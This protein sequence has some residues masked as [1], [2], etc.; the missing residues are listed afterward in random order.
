MAR[1]QN[2][3]ATALETATVNRGDVLATVEAEGHVESAH[4]VEVSCKVDG[5][6]TILW[7]VPDGT[8]LNAGDELVRFDSSGVEDL[9]SQQTIVVERAKAAQ[10]AAEHELAAARLALPEYVEGTF[11]ELDQEAAAAIVKAG[12]DLQM[13]RQGLAATKRLMR[14]GYVPPTQLEAHQSGVEQA[15]LQLDIARRAKTVL[16]TYNLPKMTQDLRSRLE[17]AAALVRSTTAEYELAQLQLGRYHRQL[18]HCVVRAPRGGLAI[19]ANDPGRRS[20][21]TPQIELGALVRQHQTVI[22]LPDLSTMRVRSLVHESSVL[23]VHP[24]HRAAVRVRGRDL[25]AVITEVANQPA[26]LHRSQQHL[27]YF[28]VS[29]LIDERSPGLRPGETADLTILLDYR[30]DVL[31]APLETVVKQDD[32]VFVWV[33]HDGTVEP[34]RVELGT[35]GDDM[36]EVRRGLSEGERLLLNPR[37]KL[38]ELGESPFEGEAHPFDKTESVSTAGRGLVVQAAGG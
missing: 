17:T 29:A 35:F 1:Y 11:V 15:V 14:L 24:G 27:K 18:E 13:A 5:G 34:R 10:I 12:H 31:C 7:I 33:D 9:L 26:A 16:E 4:N 38:P 25:P 23:R 21:E 32:G 30:P 37:D 36:A 20:G 19:H 8:P 28:V 2:S 22:W 6:S 3:P